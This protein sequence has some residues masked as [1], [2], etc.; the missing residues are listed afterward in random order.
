MR[1]ELS[2]CPSVTFKYFEC[3]KIHTN[4]KNGAVETS[5]YRSEELSRCAPNDDPTGVET[6][7]VVER[8][9]MLASVVTEWLY[10]R[11]SIIHITTLCKLI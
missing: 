8:C 1:T 3:S 6:C 2:L 5:K 11:F 4:M 7:W 9:V 10:P